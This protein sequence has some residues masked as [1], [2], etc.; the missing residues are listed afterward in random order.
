M[1]STLAAAYSADDTKPNA[2][3]R[4][5][6]F[7]IWLLH[8]FTTKEGLLG[9]YNYKYLFTPSYP[10]RD[11]ITRKRGLQVVR[12]DQPFFSLNEDVPVALGLLLG[13]QHALSMLAGVITPPMIIGSVA[14]LPTQLTQYLVSASLISSGIL[15]AVQI[16]RFRIVFHFIPYRFR[17]AIG[18]WNFLCCG[19]WHCRESTS[20]DVQDWFLS[21]F[22]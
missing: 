13:L 15:S 14:K 8:K 4:L 1:D 20:C 10:F 3:Q 6:I 11:W 2:L 21:K 22:E 12:V 18:G 16:T 7:F 5:R 19:T 9:D 17:I